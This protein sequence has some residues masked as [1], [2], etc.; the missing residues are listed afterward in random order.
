MLNMPIF[1]KRNSAAAM[2]PMAKPWRL[3]AS[4]VRVRRS[5]GDSAVYFAFTGHLDEQ[6]VVGRF[7]YAP[8]VVV[9]IDGKDVVGQFHSGSTGLVKFMDVVCLSHG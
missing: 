8:M 3:K 2:A 1:P 7:F 9:V 6:G 4:W 5:A